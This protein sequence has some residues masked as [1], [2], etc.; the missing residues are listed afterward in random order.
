MV[1]VPG[2][3]TVMVADFSPVEGAA[4][5]STRTWPLTMSFWGPPELMWKVYWPGASNLTNPLQRADQLSLG[6]PAPGSP[7]YSNLTVRSMRVEAGDPE[8]VLFPKN[9]AVR[10]W[11]RRAPTTPSAPLASTNMG[12]PVT[13]L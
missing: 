11:L 12:S 10:P 4:N 9:S 3:E 13:L 1:M 2:A 8:R 7:V 5:V 6:T